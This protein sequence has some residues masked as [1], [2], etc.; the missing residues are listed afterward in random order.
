MPDLRSIQQHP[1]GYR[2]PDSHG[3]RPTSYPLPLRADVA[4]RPYGFRRAHPYAVQQQKSRSRLNRAGQNRPVQSDVPYCKIALVE[5]KLPQNW[6]ISISTYHGLLIPCKRTCARQGI[7]QPLV[8]GGH[9]S[10]PLHLIPHEKAQL[11]AYMHRT[12]RRNSLL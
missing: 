3:I 4:I 10:P 8:A 12:N 5:L 9:G 1:I 6:A 11:H 7:S 2:K